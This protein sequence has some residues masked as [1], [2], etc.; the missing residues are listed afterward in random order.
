MR[1][2]QARLFSLVQHFD[3]TA[4]QQ[5]AQ[6]KFGLVVFAFPAQQRFTKTDGKT[7][8]FHAAPACYLEMPGTEAGVGSGAE[9]EAALAE[10]RQRVRLVRVGMEQFARLLVEYLS[11]LCSACGI[12]PQRT[13]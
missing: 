3:V 4:Q 1:A 8:H 12:A 10:T 9:C 6:G 11:G 13:R 5:N 7:Q 2:K